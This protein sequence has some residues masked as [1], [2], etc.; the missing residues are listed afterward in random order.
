MDQLTWPEAENS[1]SVS[2]CRCSAVARSAVGTATN[3]RSCQ[4]SAAPSPS[5]LPYSLPDFWLRKLALNRGWRLSPH[6]SPHST[7]PTEKTAAKVASI[8]AA[9]FIF[10]PAE[11][12]SC[13]QLAQLKLGK[14]PPLSASL[15]PYRSRHNHALVARLRVTVHTATPVSSPKVPSWRARSA[16][17]S[18]LADWEFRPDLDP[19]DERR[20]TDIQQELL[21]QRRHYFLRVPAHSVTRR[22]ASRNLKC[23]C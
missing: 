16:L 4:T 15:S 8:R 1:P 5:F 19:G 12:S 7:L 17:I 6:G 9:A 21:H 23:D 10:F 18:D 11:G 22:L 3:S 14:S 20:Q 13:L 2:D